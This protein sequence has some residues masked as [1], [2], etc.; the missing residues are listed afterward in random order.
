MD[1]EQWGHKKN[2]VEQWEG[3]SQSRREGRKCCSLLESPS[4]SSPPTQMCH[5]FKKETQSLKVHLG[6]WLLPTC[7]MGPLEV[8]ILIHILHIPFRPST[9]WYASTQILIIAKLSPPPHHQDISTIHISI[10]VN[11][12]A[13]PSSLCHLLVTAQFQVS[14]IM[15]FFPF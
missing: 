3:V 14:Y 6:N 5:G 13:P 4:P 1:K 7:A 8:E 15:F 12:Q 9:L 2:D 11:N 10:S